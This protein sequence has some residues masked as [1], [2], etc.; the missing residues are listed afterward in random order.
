M[1]C[2]ADSFRIANQ[3]A[4]QSKAYEMVFAV[5]SKGAHQGTSSLRMPP[6]AFKLLKLYLIVTKVRVIICIFELEIFENIHELEGRCYRSFVNWV[7]WSFLV[8]QNFATSWSGGASKLCTNGNYLRSLPTSISS[9]ANW[10]E[11][12]ISMHQWTSLSSEFPSTHVKE[13]IFRFY[14]FRE[15][16]RII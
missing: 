6:D 15:Y 9:V 12:V 16:F 13:W 14:Q 11:V 7:V 8:A 3:P 2:L 5:Y 1:V 4:R 10:A